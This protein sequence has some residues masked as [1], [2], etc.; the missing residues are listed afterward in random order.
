MNDT[1][2][3]T[4]WLTDL[5]AEVEAFDGEMFPPREERDKEESVIGECPAG[6]R[7]YFAFAQYC[8]REIAQA[9]LDGK[10]SSKADHDEIGSRI[11]LLKLKKEVADD[12]FVACLAEYFDD[13]TKA[14][15][16]HVREGWAVVRCKK[17]GSSPENP[18]D[19]FRRLGI[20][21]SE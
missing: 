19:F 6:L 9:K 8:E 20:I 3:P 1:K 10:F 21:G 12:I 5:L 18:M 4:Q 13:W 7:K 15:H 11:A 16:L 17:C 14:G 2:N